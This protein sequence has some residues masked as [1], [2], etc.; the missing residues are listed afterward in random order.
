MRNPSATS[1]PGW[2]T[3]R[4]AVPRCGQVAVCTMNGWQTN[5]SPARPVASTVRLSTDGGSWAAAAPKAMP[6][7]PAGAST[8]GTHRCDPSTSRVGASSGPTSE[9]R[10]SASRPRPRERTLARNSWPPR[11]EASMWWPA[12]PGS[13]S[14][15][16]RTGTVPP[17]PARL[18]HRPRPSSSS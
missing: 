15:G 14:D 12:S 10:N 7:S 5:T 11:N 3:R 18:V 2:A 17:T 13:S 4:A 6:A 8:R 16:K 1:T 9:N